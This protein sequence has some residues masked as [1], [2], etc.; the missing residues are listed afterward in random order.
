MTQV[1]N[2]QD[3]KLGIIGIGAMGKGLLYQAG[4]TPEVTAAVVCDIDMARCEAAARFFGIAYR[5]VATAE[6]MEQAITE[7]VLAVCTDGDMLA[8]CGQLDAVIEATGTIMDGGRLAVSALKAK[9]HL[10]LMN[11]EI[12]LIFGPYFQQLAAEN[13][14][15][16]TSA[17]GD[18][19]GVLKHMMDDINRW[20]FKTV[21]A[22]N[23]K[24]FLNRYAHPDMM[25][26]EARKRNLDVRA[27]TS[28]T[29]GTKLNIEMALIANAE[30]LQ[31]ICPGM[32]GPRL[33]NIS[34]VM[35]AY[36]FPSL[37]DKQQ[38]WVD[39]I[40]GAE[41]G[42]G[43]FVIGY[44]DHPYQQDMLQYYKMGAGP[45]YLFYRHY[46]LCHIEALSTVVQAVRQKKAVM[47]P[48]HGFVTNV[49]AYAKRDLAAGDM[50]DGIGGFSCYGLIE[51]REDN[52]IAPGLPICLTDQ[53]RLKRSVKKDEKI[54]WDDVEI[55]NER[56]DFSLFRL[57]SLAGGNTTL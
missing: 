38:P 43:V 36:D 24:G 49:Y 42:G 41:P 21:M 28:Y 6:E 33:E 34:Q 15:V 35:G 26:E 25:I 10:I 56:L 48:E 31:T 57:A 23:V 52:L 50:L 54:L 12:D 20:G 2:D 53:I 7:G 3:I 9:K 8:R 55:N 51:N 4:I 44:C 29:D 17:D 19:Y 1:K 18:Q 39:Y 46:H 30:G 22:G 40:L 37:W 13:G 32:Q 27:C 14:V 5:R 45:F 47:Q 11:S 16:C